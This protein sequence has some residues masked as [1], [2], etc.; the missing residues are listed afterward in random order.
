MVK[1]R[2]REWGA[3]VS[4]Q[5]VKLNNDKRA[6]LH[7]MMLLLS[8]SGCCIM[9]KG[10][11]LWLNVFSMISHCGDIRAHELRQT[12][13]SFQ[14]PQECFPIGAL[15]PL[16]ASLIRMMYSHTTTTFLVHFNTK[17]LTYGSVV[18][19]NLSELEDEDSLS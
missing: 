19:L 4:W 3:A 14:N 5:S 8:P 12:N 6:Q 10:R 2:W 17:A 11:L 18:D 15:S 1:Q 9:G 13:T 7:G 16:S